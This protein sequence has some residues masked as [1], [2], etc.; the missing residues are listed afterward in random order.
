MRLLKSK[1]TRQEQQRFRQ[2]LSSAKAGCLALNSSSVPSSSSSPSSSSASSGPS[3]LSSS[4]ENRAIC[5]NEVREGIEVCDGTALEGETCETRGFSAGT[6]ACKTDCAAFDTSGCSMCG[7]NTCDL[8]FAETLQNC[9]HDCSPPG[10]QT[11]NDNDS[12]PDQWEQFYFNDPSNSVTPETQSGDDDPDLDGLTNREEYEF[13]TNP[14]MKFSYHEADSN[15]TDWDSVS[16][17]DEVHLYH[18]NP[19]NPDTDADGLLDSEEIFMRHSDPVHKD[20]WSYL[21]TDGQGVVHTRTQDGL[22]VHDAISGDLHVTAFMYFSDTPDS[23][24]N[25]P[26][27]GPNPDPWRNV[28]SFE[29]LKRGVAHWADAGVTEVGFFWGISTLEDQ[30]RS[31]PGY[32]NQYIDQLEQIA[33][34][35]NIHI[36]YGLMFGLDWNQ[37]FDDPHSPTNQFARYG[38]A[39]R[40]VTQYTHSREFMIEHEWPIRVHLLPA[41][42]QGLFSF[43]AQNIQRLTDN[44]SML[45]A[46]GV[47]MDFYLPML[48]TY[49]DGTLVEDPPRDGSWNYHS[50]QNSMH[51]ILLTTYGSGF[52]PMFNWDQGYYATGTYLRSRSRPYERD[53]WAKKMFIQKQ[54]L[55]SFSV[56]LMLN[57]WWPF[58]GNRGW[59]YPNVSSYTTY[60]PAETPTMLSFAFG[61]D[62]DKTNFPDLQFDHVYLYPDQ[63][64]DHTGALQAEYHQ[65]GILVSMEPQD[66][67]AS[68]GTFRSGRYNAM[69]ISVQR[70]DSLPLTFSAKLQDQFGAEVLPSPDSYLFEV[71]TDR[72]RAI[73]SWIPGNN[74]NSLYWITFTVK[75]GAS[76]DS[77][78]SIPVFVR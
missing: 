70:Q 72:K 30:D 59:A 1:T 28:T 12:L 18:T 66:Y 65:N 54:L 36:T 45:Q 61:R 46:P 19:L 42:E 7:N 9:P 64:F 14:Y 16:D 60:G 62:L 27:M 39:I 73:F 25:E 51:R 71:S 35:K 47:L 50:V 75:N 15:D 13:R 5:G 21:F 49:Q 57:T 41:W 67:R 22:R 63:Y 26:Y 33:R 2:A 10:L 43:N 24:S 37:F 29:E 74:R 38:R 52:N 58:R 68:P 77:T 4:S 3:Q 17:G 69:T 32:Q 48:Y 40:E 53:D 34:Q 56:G 55:G 6:L 44:Y 23:R 76:L 20:T 78:Q 31:T 8:W 11:D